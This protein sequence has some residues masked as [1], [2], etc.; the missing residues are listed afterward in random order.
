LK[1]DVNKTEEGSS[2]DCDWKAENR[3][4]KIRFLPRLRLL[5]LEF[6]IYSQIQ[7]MSI[8]TEMRRIRNYTEIFVLKNLECVSV[9]IL[10]FESGH[11]YNFNP[12]IFL[13]FNFVLS[14]FLKSR[15]TDFRMNKLRGILIIAF[16]LSNLGAWLFLKQICRKLL[17]KNWYLNVF[18]LSQHT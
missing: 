7:C 8:H 2:I 10:N 14:S 6:S 3:K 18:I 17:H 4:T 5:N 12:K 13:P 1:F 11:I 15:Y 9:N 16:F